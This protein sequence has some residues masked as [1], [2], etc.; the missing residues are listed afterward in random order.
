[1]RELPNGPDDLSEDL[2]SV[3]LRVDGESPFAAFEEP[4]IAAAQVA[5]FASMDACGD[6]ICL[7]ALFRPQSLRDATPGAAGRTHVYAF[8]NQLGTHASI[9]GDQSYPF[10]ILPSWF[11]FDG[12]RIIS[13][14]QMYPV[15]KSFHQRP[16]PS[17]SQGN[18]ARI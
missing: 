2:H 3:V 9:G 15:L 7:A 18:A 8:E 6:V 13:A 14:T 12:G 5:A 16:I 1:L 17:P 4:E 11:P 10:V